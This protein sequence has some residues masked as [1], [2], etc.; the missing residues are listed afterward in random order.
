MSLASKIAETIRNSRSVLIAIHEAPDGDAVGS[1]L[2]MGAA[3]RLIGKDVVMYSHDPIPVKHRF[4][5]GWEKVISDTTLLEG[6]IFDLFIM[7]DC[8]DRNRCGKFMTEYK[9][10]NKLVNIDH[11]VSNSMFGDINYVEHS[12]SCKGEEVYSVIKTLMSNIPTDVATALL[13]AI[14]DDTG[15]MRYIST[16]SHTLRVAAEL[17]DSGANCSKVSEQLFFSVSKQKVELMSRVFSTLTFCEDS[18]IAYM[19]MRLEDLERTKALT[20]DS[21]GLIDIPRS[22][23]GVEVAFLVKEVAKDKYKFSFRSRGKVDLNEFC[24]NYGG[25]GHKVAAGCT[26]NSGLDHALASVLAGLS[27]LV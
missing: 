25:G 11:H 20:E 12:S 8:G 1:M 9:G 23:A 2:A 24:S 22:V 26:I 16:T 3:L 19:V 14:Y 7:L 6:K 15:G 10:Y 17:V 4:L 13:T 5:S 18:K 27:K 21:E